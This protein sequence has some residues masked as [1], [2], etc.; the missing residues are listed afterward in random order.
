[1]CIQMYL[2]TALALGHLVVEHNYNNT[3]HLTSRI[4]RDVNCLEWPEAIL[5][6]K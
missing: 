6:I 2:Y 1:M 4:G 5:I 3:L